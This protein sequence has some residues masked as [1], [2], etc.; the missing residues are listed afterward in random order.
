MLASNADVS[1]FN[2]IEQTGRFIQGEDD[3][4]AW[5]QDEDD[6]LEPLMLAGEEEE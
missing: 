4:F 3:N 1:I 6:L 2:W 5:S